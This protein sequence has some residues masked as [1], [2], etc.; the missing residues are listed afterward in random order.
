[1]INIFILI[2]ITISTV[3][4]VGMKFADKLLSA[5]F[6][7]SGLLYGIGAAFWLYILRIGSITQFLVCYDL[8]LPTSI[9]CI[10]ANLNQIFFTE[11]Q[12]K[13]DTYHIFDT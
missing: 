12:V 1:M 13:N 5:T 4:L 3:G 10:L 8:E 6:I 7:L 11:H 2:Y 9:L